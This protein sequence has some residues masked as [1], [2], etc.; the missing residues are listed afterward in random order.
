MCPTVCAYSVVMTVPGSRVRSG[1]NAEELT[2]STTGPLRPSQ[3]RPEIVRRGW[4]VQ[5]PIDGLRGRG[6][7]GLVRS[8]HRREVS[9]VARTRQ[10]I[11]RAEHDSVVRTLPPERTG[12]ARRRKTHRYSGPARRANHFHMA[13]AEVVL[14]SREKISAFPKCKSVVSSA[15]S[16]PA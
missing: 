5:G 2:V 10:K 15:P 12:G 8:P 6:N 16:H 14:P 1:A 3:R 11:P 9:Y 13:Q 7:F 4:S